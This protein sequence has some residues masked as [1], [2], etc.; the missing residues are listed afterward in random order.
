MTGF[1]ILVVDDDADLRESVAECLE[2]EGH[3]VLTAEN[4]QRALEL[5]SSGILPDLILLDLMMPDMDGWAFRARQL[6]DPKLRAIPV[7]V[8]TAHAAP[9]EIT[10]E[11]GAV[12][13]LKKPL[14]LETLI[15][16]V[17]EV[18]ARLKPAARS[19]S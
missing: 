6:E 17:G 1:T 2:A 10:E 11:L 18:A 5:S 13:L 8:F 12:G 3:T 7:L 14:R 16:A 9:H 19:D 15:A 4:G